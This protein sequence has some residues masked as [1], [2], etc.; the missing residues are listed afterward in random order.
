MLSQYVAA[1]SLFLPTSSFIVPNYFTLL[2]TKK[3]LRPHTLEPKF[4]KTIRVSDSL[5]TGE[6]Q[7]DN[8]AARAGL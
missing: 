3:E 6:N 2:F 1:S 8:I 7:I 5:R 4:V